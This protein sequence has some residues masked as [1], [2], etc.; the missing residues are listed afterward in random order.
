MLPAIVNLYLQFQLFEGLCSLA[1]HKGLLHQCDFYGS[2]AAGDAIK[3]AFKLGG[4]KP[5][6]DLIKIITGQREI[7]SKSLMRYCKPLNDWL[8]TENDTA[9]DCYGWG[10]DWPANAMKSL[11]KNRC[12]KK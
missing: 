12:G 4:S 3:K 2:K 8:K 9:K 11:E 5:P 1:G 10:Y 6:G 7:S